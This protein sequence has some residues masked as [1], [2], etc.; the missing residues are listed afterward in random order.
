[1]PYTNVWSSLSPTDATAA[2]AIDD[3]IRKARL[4]LEERLLG[5]VFNAPFTAD[6]LVVRPEILGNVVGK[7]YNF[8][9]SEL[10][11]LGDFVADLDYTD[12][13]LQVINSGAAQA[14][15]VPLNI[16]IG[17]TITRMKMG[18]NPNTHTIAFELW[19]ASLTLGTS[20]L[21]SG[22]FTSSAGAFL[23]LDSGVIAVP[24][25]SGSAYALKI[26]FSGAGNLFFHSGQL[27]YTVAD[28]RITR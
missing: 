3:E 7:E 22:P 23:Q 12:D 9:W 24:L 14:I 21:V 4:D 25:A 2:N 27:L 10:T 13:R 20:A 6:P 15:Y 5:G 19:A 28:C 26:K 16:P 1:M 11:G 18:V 8:H 17:A